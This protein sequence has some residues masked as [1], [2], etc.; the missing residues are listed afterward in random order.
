MPDSA[1]E[2][3]S[4][5]LETFEGRL[6][7]LIAAVEA[8]PGPI[9]YRRGGEIIATSSFSRGVRMFDFHHHHRGRKRD[10]LMG[11]LTLALTGEDLDEI[12]TEVANAVAEARRE[13]WA[14]REAA[15]G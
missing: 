4:I 2:D 9:A 14:E 5:D 15:S 8:E 3:R 10:R 11:A 6:S 13:I 7:D 12:E 1:L